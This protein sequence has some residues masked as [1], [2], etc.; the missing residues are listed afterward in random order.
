V[1]FRLALLLLLLIQEFPIV[2]DAAY[3]RDGARRDLDQVQIFFPGHFQRF[4]RWQD[5]NLLAFVINYADFA[6]SDT[7]I[8]AD[9]TFFDTILRQPTGPPKDPKL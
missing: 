1:F 6:G 4:E 3:G 7:I 9:K 5:T 8:R 2:H